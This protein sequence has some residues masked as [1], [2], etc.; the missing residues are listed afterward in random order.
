MQTLVFPQPPSLNKWI[1]T[2]RKNPYES[3][4]QKQAWTSAICQIIK[5]TELTPVIDTC[6]VSLSFS[7]KRKNQDFDNTSSVAFKVGLDALV[8]SKILKNDSMANI[9]SPTVISWFKQE[10]EPVCIM[11]IFECQ[12]EFYKYFQGQ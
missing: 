7:Y 4:K 2:A 11:R 9:N 12:K 5:E 3:N 6:W 8:K 1:D 10:I